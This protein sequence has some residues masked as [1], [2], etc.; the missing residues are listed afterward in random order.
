MKISFSRSTVL[1]F[2]AI[3]VL[4]AALPSAI[5]RLIQTGSPYL[6]TREFFDDIL[7]RFSGAGRLRF[8]VQPTVALVIGVRDGIK[9]A[10]EGHLPF[11]MALLSQP[12]HKYDLL[13][14]AFASVR[15]LV[16]IAIIFDV[17]C[18]FLIFR[19]IHPGAALLVGPILIAIPYAASRALAHR[20]FTQAHSRGQV[21][22]R[23]T[24]P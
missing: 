11:V 21:G 17:I 5:R 15:D 2:L 20:F 9:D 10:R 18:Q 12:A 19:R 1:S 6:L 24:R 7:A 3:A 22:P 13:R 14:S 23:V 8:I 16:S 4:L